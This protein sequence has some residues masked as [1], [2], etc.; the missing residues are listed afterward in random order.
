MLTFDTQ[1]TFLLE[2]RNQT[3]LTG[4]EGINIGAPPILQL[5]LAPPGIGAANYHDRVD[6][7]ASRFCIQPE[8]RNHMHLTAV[9]FRIPFY[10]AFGLVGFSNAYAACKLDSPALTPAMIADFLQKP[11]IILNHDAGSKRGAHEL[12]VFISQYATAGPAVTQAI[13]SIIPSATLRQRAAI[14]KGLYT[15]VA[16]CRATDPAIATRIESAVKL[17]RDKD[18]MLGYLLAASL[19]DPSAGN[20]HPQVFTGFT[21]AKPSARASG[22]IGEP[23]PTNPGSLK[24]SDPF[25]PPDGWR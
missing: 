10:V 6:P 2:K 17:I 14:G 13:K 11:E 8:Q 22:L 4:R 24:L 5:P 3:A 18:V 1:E 19:S 12:S 20:P 21:S 7:E 9:S 16:F 25:G 23:S 15:A